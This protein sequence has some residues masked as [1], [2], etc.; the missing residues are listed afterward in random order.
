M[1][2]SSTFT[3]FADN[4]RNPKSLSNRLR[5]KRFQAFEEF[6]AK[7]PRPIRVLDVGGENS[8]WEK[9]GWAD[10]G[11]VQITILNVFQQEKRNANITPVVGDAT[12][13]HQFADSSFDIVF[14]NSVIE[15]LFTFEN[16]ARMAAEVR[17]VG[18]AFWVQTPNFWFPM[19]P[20]FLIPCWQW[21]PTNVRVALLRR[22]RCGWHERCPDRDR[23]KELVTEVRLMTAKELKVLFPAAKVIPE[24]FGGMVKSWSVAGGFPLSTETAS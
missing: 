8:Y 6:V 17:R 20:H 1:L 19:E 3:K 24:R 7:M 21:M 2:F 15:H 14:S 4:V 9:R 5:A 16:Q 23:A 13:L 11:D 22:W 12:N 10:R 18:K